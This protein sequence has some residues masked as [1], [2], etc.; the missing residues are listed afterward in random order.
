MNTPMRRR[1][2]ITLLGGAAAAWPRVARAQQP[3]MPVIGW[4]DHRVAALSS[5]S[6][7]AFRRGLNEAGFVE[8]RNVAIEFRWAEDQLDRLP[9]MAADLVRRGVAVIVTNNASTPA[10]KAATSTIPIVFVGG[11]DPVEAGFV[12]SLN[13]PSGNVTGVSFTTDLV[14]AKRL[15]LL[16]ELVPKPAVIALGRKILIVKAGKA[17]SMPPSR[18]S[19]KRAPA[20]CSSAPVGFTSAGV[21]KSSH[22]PAAMRCRLATRCASSSWPAV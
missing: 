15:E 6:V 9:A 20:C 17:R 21:D 13:R 7:A 5:N 4:L 22:W 3:A 14:L 18:R 10:A 19:S 16:H 11:A 12:T 2:F 1:E 8:A